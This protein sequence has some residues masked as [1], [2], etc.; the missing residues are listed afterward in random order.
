MHPCLIWTRVFFIKEDFMRYQKPKGT[1]DILPGDSEKWQY[2]ESIAQDTFNKYRFSEIRTPIF[3]SYEVFE[4]SSGDTSDIVSKEMYDFKDKGDRHIALRP[5]GTA[6]VVRAYVENK[7]YG[8]EHIKPYKVWYKGPMFR[9]ERPQS[10]RQR[11]FHQIGV[12]AFSSDSPELDAEIISVGLEFLNRLGIKN[13]KVALNSLGDPESRAAY[14]PERGPPP[15]PSRNA[16]SWGT[17][18]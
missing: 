15:R 18:R 16:R 11:Q 5:E 9:Y 1:M 10:G 8:P 14:R 12:E 2:V 17:W 3:E 4:R 7:L 13:L 6:G